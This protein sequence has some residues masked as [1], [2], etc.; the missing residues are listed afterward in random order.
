M[1]VDCVCDVLLVLEA[2]VV[3]FRVQPKVRCHLNH[4]LLHLCQACRGRRLSTT[5]GRD[6]GATSAVSVP[7]NTCGDVLSPPNQT[8]E[9]LAVQVHDMVVDACTHPH[10][11]KKR[12]CALG[13]RW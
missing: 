5:G 2:V 12:R 10:S 8:V 9:H 7:V 13:G 6:G 11:S 1:N 3:E 4:T